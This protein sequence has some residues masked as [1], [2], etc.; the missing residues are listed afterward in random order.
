MP[1]LDSPYLED[2]S[3]RI[4]PV[5]LRQEAGCIWSTRRIGASIVNGSNTCIRLRLRRLRS[6][7]S[8]PFW[9][10]QLHSSNTYYLSKL[11]FELV[12]LQSSSRKYP[13]QQKNASVSDEGPRKNNLSPG[14]FRAERLAVIE[15]SLARDLCSSIFKSEVVTRG[16]ESVALLCR[17][18]K[19]EW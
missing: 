7:S 10:T 11:L 17:D 13:C 19:R 18:V 4:I 3:V 15:D 9:C 6:S 16:D 2:T 1:S 14:C 5:P 8:C 12:P